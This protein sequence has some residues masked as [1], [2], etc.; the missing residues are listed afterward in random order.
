MQQ[1]GAGMGFEKGKRPAHRRGR[2]PQLPAGPGQASLID[3]RH[4][5][6]ASMRSMI[7]PPYG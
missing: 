3:R 2:A 4:E 1:F 7:T 5:Y 6:I